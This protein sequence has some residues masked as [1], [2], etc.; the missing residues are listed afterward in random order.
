MRSQRVSG[1]CK[2]PFWTLVG[3][4]SSGGI[5]ESRLG[6]WVSWLIPAKQGQGWGPFSA[7]VEQEQEMKL[8]WVVDRLPEISVS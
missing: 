1:V 4:L 8:G 5:P 6:V 7:K 2:V 3:L